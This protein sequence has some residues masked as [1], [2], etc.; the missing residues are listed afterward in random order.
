MKHYHEI[1]FGGK[2]IPQLKSVSRL[3][4]LIRKR[5]LT[6]G[7]YKCVTPSGVSHFLTFA[8]TAY[9]AKGY[10]KKPQAKSKAGK[11]R[12]PHAVWNVIQTK[13]TI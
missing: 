7:T 4:T 2:V 6:E 11:K 8:T 13:I 10:G 5:K 12:V 3:R 9:N 1:S